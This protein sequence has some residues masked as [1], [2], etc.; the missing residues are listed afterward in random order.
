MRV[1]ELEAACHA[2]SFESSLRRAMAQTSPACSVSATTDSNDSSHSYVHADDTFDSSAAA[3]SYQQHHF[4]DEFRQQPGEEQH[5]CGREYQES[6][7]GQDGESTE[8]VDEYLRRNEGSDTESQASTSETEISGLKQ[9]RR[10]WEAE[11][12]ELLREMHDLRSHTNCAAVTCC[13]LPH[14]CM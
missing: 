12:E 14:L 3:S 6:G 11:R 9:Q 2:A 13:I 8:G 5:S 1:E 7:A 10:E 4:N